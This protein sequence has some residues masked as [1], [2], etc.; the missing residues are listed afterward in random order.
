[1]YRLHLLAELLAWQLE[2]FGL[3]L[4]EPLR[5]DEIGIGAVLHDVANSHV[6][7]HIT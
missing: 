7:V 1:M 2:L 3:A 6:S 5:E 4:V